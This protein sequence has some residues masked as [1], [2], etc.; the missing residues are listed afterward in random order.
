MDKIFKLMSCLNNFLSFFNFNF[1]F[2]VD[3]SITLHARNMPYMNSM[4]I[5]QK[6]SNILVVDYMDS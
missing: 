1:N 6:M 4:C 3:L 2:Y 5:C